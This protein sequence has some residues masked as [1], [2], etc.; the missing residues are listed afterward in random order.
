MSVPEK[1]RALAKIHDERGG[2]YGDNYKYGGMILLGLFPEGLHL[3]TEE[4][5][6]RFHLL[7]YMAGKLSR[8]ARML[9][10]G[11]HRDSLDDLAVYSQLLAEYDEEC[12]K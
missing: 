6:N 4:E 3:E 12:G 5:F 8:Y 2:L 11:G 10:R 7:V 9:K 1:L